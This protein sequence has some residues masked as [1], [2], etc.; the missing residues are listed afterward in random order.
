[1]PGTHHTDKQVQR[2]MTLRKT[3]TQAVA[4][5]KADISERSA[6]AI[7]KDPRPPSQ[8]KAKRTWRTRK[9]PLL[10]VWP[11]VE[12]MLKETPG[13]LAV[14]IFE[15]LQ[16]ESGD[17]DVPDGVRRTLERRIARWRALHGPDQEVFFPQRHPPGRQALSDFTV[18][19]DLGV[20]LAGALFPHRLYHFRL[21]Y[22]GWEHVRVILGGESFT[23]VAEGLQEALW[24]LGGVPAEHRTDSLSAAFKNLNRDAQEDFTRRYTELCRHYGMEGTRNNPGVANENGSIEVSHAHLKRRID[25][26]LLRRHSRDFASLDDYRGF[27]ARLV[28]RHN[29]RRRALVTA[30]RAVL[31]DLPEH[32]TADFAALTVP[33]T[34]NSTISVDKVLYTVPSRLIGQKLK[35][36]L[37]DDRL[38]GFLGATSVITLERGRASG[39]HRGHVI[40]FH[41]VIGTLK[42]KPQ[43]LRHLIYRDAL[44]PRPVYRQVWEA[45]DAELPARHACRVMVGLLALAA[46]GGCEAALAQ[47]LEDLLAVGDRPDL[48]ALTAALRPKPATVTDV[49]I[50][51]PDPAG[52]DRLLPAATR[53]IP[54]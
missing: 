19:D 31:G 41:H 30:E 11:R 43:A 50:T 7:D 52:Y 53:E 5:A 39:N 32:R 49:A 54:A 12:E 17:D 42:R 33:V 35:I 6:R 8:R 34:R 23:A 38:E 26:A 40:D 16:E 20:T 37:H 51:P 46:D 2:Y 27:L 3:H 44:F 1:M 14:S 15:A 28:E 25:Q 36:H 9:D 22:S 18:A 21:A 45:L 29:T 4:A 24:G 47:R 48:E 13:L 10:A